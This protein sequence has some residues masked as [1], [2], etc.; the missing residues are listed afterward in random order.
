MCD[1]YIFRL[2]IALAIS[3]MV[4]ISS[5]LVLIMRCG[6]LSRAPWSIWPGTLSSF[7]SVHSI[8]P[9][10]YCCQRRSTFQLLISARSLLFGSPHFLRSIVEAFHVVSIGS[11]LQLILLHFPPVWLQY[12]LQACLY[13][14]V[15]DLVLL[16]YNTLRWAWS[17]MLI[18]V[19]SFWSLGSNQS[20]CFL[21]SLPRYVLAVLYTTCCRATHSSS[22]VE[23]AFSFQWARGLSIF[24]SR[25]SL[26]MMVLSFAVLSLIGLLV[27]S[28]LC[29]CRIPKATFASGD[30]SSS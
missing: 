10:L 21:S 12:S 9:Q 18:R 28:L 25:L 20:W 13:A 14:A 22:G 29:F 24:C 11:Y 30:R 2:A 6:M 1:V 27:P 23:F 8:L 4:G 5:R 3:S 15:V 26:W 16:I 19:C 7:G 17:V